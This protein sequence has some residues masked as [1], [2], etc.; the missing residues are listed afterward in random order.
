MSS[1]CDMAIGIEY[2]DENE[3][4]VTACCMKMMKGNEIYKKNYYDRHPDYFC[5][6]GFGCK[7]VEEIRKRL[8][9]DDEE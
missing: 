8:E 9:G 1:L 5:R 7:T 4:H 2:P 3:N 6:E